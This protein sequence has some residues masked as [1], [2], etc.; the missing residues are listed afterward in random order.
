VTNIARSKQPTNAQAE[1]KAHEKHFVRIISDYEKDP[2][3]WFD[4]LCHCHCTHGKGKD[5][6]KA[7]N[8]LSH[9]RALGWEVKF[10]GK[11]KQRQGK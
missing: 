11:S 8:A 6:D 7:E 1:R 9:L 10:V 2:A 5:A 3:Y 4:M